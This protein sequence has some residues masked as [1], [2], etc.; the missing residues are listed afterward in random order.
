LN[1]HYYSIAV[2]YRK[3]ELE[4]AMLMNLHKRNWTE[5]LKLRDFKLHKESNEKAIKVRDSIL[6]RLRRPRDPLGC[7]AMLSLS[8]AYNKSLQEEATL[9]AEQ[10]KTRHVGKQDPKRHLEEAVEK[11]MGDQVVQNLGAMLLAEL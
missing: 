9:T 5:G 1:R 7:Q 8:A 3:T 10:L 2:N 6:I 11:A 4:Q